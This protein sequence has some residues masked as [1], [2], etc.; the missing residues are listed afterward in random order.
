MLSLMRNRYRLVKY[1]IPFFLLTY[2]LIAGMNL[3]ITGSSKEI[4]PFFAWTLF[5][6]TP[7][8][9]KLERAVV[10]HSIDGKRIPELAT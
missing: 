4:F 3:L 6:H 8:W 9:H 7:G 10:V 5:S 1:G 2:L